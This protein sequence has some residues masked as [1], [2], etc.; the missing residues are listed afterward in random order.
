M[1]WKLAKQDITFLCAAEVNLWSLQFFT[2]NFKG[3]IKLGVEIVHMLDGGW[4]ESR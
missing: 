1:K 4:F 3:A 2:Q